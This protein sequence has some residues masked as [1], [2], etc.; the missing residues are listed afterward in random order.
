M[1]KVQCSNADNCEVFI[2]G[3]FCPHKDP[4][5]RT[6]WCKTGLC[7]FTNKDVSCEKISNKH[8]M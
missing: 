1:S 3:V 6:E 5:I 7:Y 4:H 8:S 2:N